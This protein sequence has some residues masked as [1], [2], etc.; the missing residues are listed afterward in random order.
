[1]LYTTRTS[2][3]LVA[4]RPTRLI[5]LI[6]RPSILETAIPHLVHRAFCHR[7]VRAVRVG[8]DGEDRSAFYAGL[9][10]AITSIVF[11]SDKR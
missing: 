4:S 10:S 7:L 8:F 5:D 9:R 1:M 11:W 6:E 3:K 2:A